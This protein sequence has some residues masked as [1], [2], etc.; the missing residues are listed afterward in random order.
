MIK[1]AG[2]TRIALPET[3]LALGGIVLGGGLRETAAVKAAFSWKSYLGGE[4]RKGAPVFD[5]L[6]S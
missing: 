6:F 5:T 3:V 2:Q 1:R 4:M